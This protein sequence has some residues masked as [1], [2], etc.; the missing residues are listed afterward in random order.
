MKNLSSQK[1]EKSLI[2]RLRSETGQFRI[3]VYQNSTLSK[4]GEEVLKLLKQTQKIFYDKEMN[5]E[6]E[7]NNGN[8]LISSLNLNSL[9]I[10]TRQAIEKTIG[11]KRILSI[12][13]AEGCQFLPISREQLEKFAAALERVIRESKMIVD[14]LLELFRYF[15]DFM[16]LA[17][18]PNADADLREVMRASRVRE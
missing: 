6:L 15:F 14:F 9:L 7:L 8:I 16:E 11:D 18:N 3:Q 1:E 13:Y 5:R 10:Q 12:T 17:N 4:L 2:L